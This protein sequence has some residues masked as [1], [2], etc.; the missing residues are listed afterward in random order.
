MWRGNEAA[1][2]WRDRDSWGLDGLAEASVLL[3]R[4]PGRVGLPQTGARE[5]VLGVL[6]TSIGVRCMVR[7]TRSRHESVSSRFDALRSTRRWTQPPANASAASSTLFCAALRRPWRGTA[8]HRQAADGALPLR[9]RGPIRSGRV[10]QNRAAQP[11]I[12]C[13]S[14]ESSRARS[15]EDLGELDGSWVSAVA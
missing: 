12:A 3:Q 6:G 13:H 14:E 2:K 4:L 7:I 15:G 9:S 10:F 5:G 8:R 11:S 1:G